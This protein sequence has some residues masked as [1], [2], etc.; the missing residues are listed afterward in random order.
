MGLRQLNDGGRIRARE[1]TVTDAKTRRFPK[2]P[3]RFSFQPARVPQAARPLQ[4]AGSRSVTATLAPGRAD[5]AIV[6]PGCS[7]WDCA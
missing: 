2:G 4:Y 3:A 5:S 6:A 7:D 1:S